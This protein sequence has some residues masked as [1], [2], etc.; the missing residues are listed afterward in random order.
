MEEELITVFYKM[1]WPLLGLSLFLFLSAIL[2][3]VFRK[4][5]FA[6]DRYDGS[7]NLITFTL[8]FFLMI[9]GVYFSFWSSRY[10]MDIENVRNNNFEYVEG[11]VIDFIR[12]RESNSPG[13]P[14]QSWPIILETGTT[15]QIAVDLHGE[16]EVDDYVSVIYLENCK[17]AILVED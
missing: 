5:I 10:V 12:E 7:R 8:V 14:N 3:F 17:L 13:D 4:K 1:L 2:V 9:G 15:N 11:V 6:D 16:V